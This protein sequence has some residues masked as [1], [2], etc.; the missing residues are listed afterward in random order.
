L[1]EGRDERKDQSYFLWSIPRD[2]LPRLIFPLGEWT[3]AEVRRYV[4]DRELGVGSRPESQEICFSSRWQE[5]VRDRWRDIG[6]EM[7]PGPIL[8]TRDRLLGQHR[9]IGY[10]TVGQRSR[11]GVAL[12]SPRYV[13]RIDPER[14][15]LILGEEGDLYHRHLLARGL[16][17]YREAGPGMSVRV[18]ARI[19]H[20]HCP[21][22]AAVR[23]LAADEVR[24][25][26][27]EPQRAI[28]PGQSVVFYDGEE[29]LGGGDIERVVE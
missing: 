24:V 6:L 25:D 21:A 3:K 17:W 12:G 29:V 8:D 23:C 19:R 1:L 7:I 10:Y 16:N 4:L 27:D 15:A 2:N 18:R 14:N 11:L 22:A 26:F 13:V 28:T 20:R 9:G 5:F